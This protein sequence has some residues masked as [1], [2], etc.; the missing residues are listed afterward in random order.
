MSEVSP[1]MS[2]VSPHMSTQKRIS[3]P[4]G[5]ARWTLI[6]RGLVATEDQHEVRCNVQLAL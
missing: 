1:H 4:T 3:T 2:E 5:K 6:A